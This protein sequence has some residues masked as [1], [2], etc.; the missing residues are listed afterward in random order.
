MIPVRNPWNVISGRKQKSTAV[1]SVSVQVLKVINNQMKSSL[2]EE[3]IP[4]EDYMVIKHI[5]LGEK[6][7]LY[8]LLAKK[9][10]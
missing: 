7:K 5:E 9:K 1:K 6:K 3:K 8:T 4:L 2:K 10:K